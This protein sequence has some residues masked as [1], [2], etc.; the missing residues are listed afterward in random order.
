MDVEVGRVV[1]PRIWTYGQTD[2]RKFIARFLSVGHDRGV[3]FA[4]VEK[5]MRSKWETRLKRDE[6]QW[7]F[8]WWRVGHDSHG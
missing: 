7:D 8:N 1:I 2:A 4:F 3:L 5:S 6:L